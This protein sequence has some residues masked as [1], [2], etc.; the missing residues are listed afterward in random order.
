[1]RTENTETENK[2]S[3]AGCLKRLIDK[4]PTQSNKNKKKG[5]N[6]QY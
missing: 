6:K 1:M 2:K 4:I 3:K 5:T